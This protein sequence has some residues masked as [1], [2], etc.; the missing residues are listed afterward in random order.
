[1]T[2]GG[3]LQGDVATAGRALFTCAKLAGFGKDTQVHAVGDGAAWI[4]SQVEDQFGDQGSYLVDFYHVCDYLSAA[5]K[6]IVTDAQG[7]SRWMDEQKTKLKT[8][9]ADELLKI[10]LEHVEAPEVDEANAPVRQCHRYLSNR[11]NQLHYQRTLAQ[12]LPIGSGEIESA[13]RYIAQQRLKRPGTG[14][15]VDNAEHMLGLRINRANCQWNAYWTSD[16]KQAA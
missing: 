15:N 4:A 8:Q 2:Y 10:L 6:A 7:Q 16:L 1:L 13:H 5:A 9:Q 3:T 14:W 11:P 12:E